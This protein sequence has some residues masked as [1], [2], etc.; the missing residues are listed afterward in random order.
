MGTPIVESDHLPFL[1]PPYH[2]WSSRDLAALGLFANK[3]TRKT[4]H[5]PSITDVMIGNLHLVFLQIRYSCLNLSPT[6]GND[7]KNGYL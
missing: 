6:Q 7:P 2:E 1:R 3:L 5:V 4:G